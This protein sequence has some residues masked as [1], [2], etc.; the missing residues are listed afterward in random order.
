MTCYYSVTIRPDDC[1]QA[2]LYQHLATMAV[3][4]VSSISICL[5]TWSLFKYLNHSFCCILHTYS[6][7]SVEVQDEQIVPLAKW[8]H[9]QLPN[10]FSSQLEE[11]ES[12]VRMEIMSL[13]RNN[14]LHFSG[15]TQIWQN[16]NDCRGCYCILP[17]E[18]NDSLQSITSAQTFYLFLFVSV[19][20]LL[21]KMTNLLC[22]CLTGR[23]GFRTSP[24]QYE[25]AQLNVS[26]Q[27]SA[28]VVYQCNFL[29]GSWQRCLR[30]WWGS[31]F[32]IQ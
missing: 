2:D 32:S 7:I 30:S 26:I 18:I 8:S 13:N 29:A 14:L 15:I 11:K 27:P 19:E 22:L 20:S 10:P 1:V 23:N 4:Q 28:F 16:A 12:R 3:F 9:H 17:S 6:V 25:F 31:F 5:V 21:N 24:H